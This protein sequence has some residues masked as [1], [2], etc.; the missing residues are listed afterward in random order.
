M[1]TG[2]RK[3]ENSTRS[4]LSSPGRP[5]AAQREQHISVWRLIAE[6]MSSEEAAVQVGA[7]A[8]VGSRWFREAGGTPQRVPLSVSSCFTQIR[9]LSRLHP[10]FCD[11]DENE[12]IGYEPLKNKRHRR[13]VPYRIVRI[14]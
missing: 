3:S 8:P 11:I 7:S 2:G 1:P 12:I 4:K 9:T 5:K 6:G 13:N 14:R 10:T